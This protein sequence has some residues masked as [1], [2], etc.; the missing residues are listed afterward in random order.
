ME[1]F[2]GQKKNVSR[3]LLTFVVHCHNTISVRCFFLIEKIL[4]KDFENFEEE[5]RKK[6]EGGMRD[7]AERESS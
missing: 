2:R 4:L 5:E 7:G 3:F 6:K 1:L